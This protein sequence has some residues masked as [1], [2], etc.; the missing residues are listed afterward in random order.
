MRLKFPDKKIMLSPPNRTDQDM[1]GKL[2]RNVWRD[3]Q[4]KLS[5]EISRREMDELYNCEFANSN[6]KNLN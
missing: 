2:K 3:K 5:C 4:R 6:N 1:T